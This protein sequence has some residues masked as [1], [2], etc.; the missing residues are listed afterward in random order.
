MND[1]TGIEEP[2]RDSKVSLL[3][4]NAV[5]LG[6]GQVAST[7]LA[8]AMTAV[9][10]RSLGAEDFG[11]YYTI[12]IMTSF[13]AVL[14]DWGQGS[15]VVREIARGRSDEPD[16]LSSAI[17]IRIVGTALGVVVAGGAA[18]AFGYDGLVVFLAPLA[19][20]FTFPNTVIQPVG[21]LFR[22]KDRMD[23][24]TF[25]LVLA[26]ALLLVAA[27]IAIQLGGGLTAIVLSQGVSAFGP[28]VVCLILVR[29]YGIKFGRPVAGTVQELFRSGAPIL[30]FS[31]TIAVQPFIDV[32]LLSVLTEPRVVGWYGA[33]RT[34]LGT[35]IAPAA[36]M[37][38]AAFPEVSRASLSIP[39]LSRLIEATARPL[40][41]ASAFGGAALFLFVDYIVV[42]IYGQGDF[43]NA[44][45]LLRT[46]APILPI[47][48]LDF[49]FGATITALGKT[50]EL[51]IAKILNIIM[52]AAIGWVAIPICQTH[53]GNGG[54]GL[55]IAFGVSEI[56]ML[57]SLF[58]LLPAGAVSRST[59]RQFFIAFPVAAISVFP[60]FVVPSL[61]LWIAAPCFVVIFTAAALLSQLLRLSDIRLV[62]DVLRGQE[63]L[64]RKPR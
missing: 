42:I 3:A 62:S 56:F 55:M 7:I 58:Y 1:H 60:F 25:V 40:L 46:A 13:I 6:L 18:N 4:R 5:H 64:F 59:V 38:A 57:I 33:A 23:L 28:L 37:A 32:L 8:I 39:K 63:S 20:L 61:S 45:Q 12:V 10:G 44:A 49:L 15:Y 41:A 53:F 30:V 11:L 31:V 24:D 2:A 47:L 16:F 36:I 50:K 14:I 34:I 27:V 17:L 54:I 26:K 29:V 19:V 9:I 43:G 22:A 48:F 51:A 35:V 21:Y 52:A